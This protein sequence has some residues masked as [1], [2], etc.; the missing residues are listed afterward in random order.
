MEIKGKDAEKLAACPFCGGSARMSRRQMR[1]YGTNYLGAK[2]IRLGV[3]AICCRCKARGPLYAATVIV[4]GSE[5]HIEWMEARAAAW[6]SAWKE[7]AN[8]K[9]KM[10]K[11]DNG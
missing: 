8:D 3:Q 1:Y 5:S 9:A 6:W 4:P 7:Y 10:D 11:V 2:K